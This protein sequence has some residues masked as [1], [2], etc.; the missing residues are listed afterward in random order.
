[1]LICNLRFTDT[2]GKEQHITIPISAITDDF[3]EKR[4]MIDGS[5]F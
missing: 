1:M 3:I 2:I 4:K 5:S